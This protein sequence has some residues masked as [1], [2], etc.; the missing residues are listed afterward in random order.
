KITLPMVEVLW[1]FSDS[2]QPLYFDPIY[3]GRTTGAERIGWEAY[4]TTVDKLKAHPAMLK[5]AG[6]NI[7]ASGINWMVLHVFAH[8]P[9]TDPHLNPGFT[10]GPWGAH[11]DRGNTWFFKS[12]PWMSYLSRC[13]YMLRQGEPVTD[14]LYYTGSRSF[15]ESGKYEIQMP[16]KEPEPETVK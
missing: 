8:H 15:G 7:F 5:S 10:C 16:G 2:H 6:D 13:Q 9:N 1:P 4:T 12:K 11:I 14:V 3:A